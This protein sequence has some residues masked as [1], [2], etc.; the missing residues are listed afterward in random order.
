MLVGAQKDVTC[1]TVKVIVAIEVR[2]CTKEVEFG[3]AIERPI[4]VRLSAADEVVAV[5]NAVGVTTIKRGTGAVVAVI[6]GPRD[7]VVTGTKRV[8]A[9]ERATR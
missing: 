7:A 8:L 1:G 5:V 4:A 3:V 6:G 9:L 2:T